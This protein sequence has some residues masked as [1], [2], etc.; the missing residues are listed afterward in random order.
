[1]HCLLSPF[2]HVWPFFNII[3]EKVKQNF[4][5]MST[6]AYILQHKICF[7]YDNLCFTASYSFTAFSY[8]LILKFNISMKIILTLSWRMSLS[9]RNKTIDL[10]CKSMDWFLYDR[11]LRPER[12]KQISEVYSE[13][14]S[15]SK[16]IFNSFS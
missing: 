12:V 15:T 5:A 11:G 14:C 6:N 2:I 16:E 7:M 13:H 9:H 10:F 4:R 8:T 1:M 3:D